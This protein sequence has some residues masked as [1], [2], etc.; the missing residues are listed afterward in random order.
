MKVAAKITT[1]PSRVRTLF[2]SAAL[3]V[4]VWLVF[5][6][7]LRHDF[8][9]FDDN[10]YV[11]GNSLTRSG[12]SWHG[13]ARAFVDTRT[14]NWHPVTLISHMLDCQLFDLK[15]GAHHF[16][17]V[18]LHSIAALLLF[19]FLRNATS[20][21]WSS[22]FIVALFAIHPLRVESVAWV[23][24]RKDV[25]SGVFFFLTLI[26]Y[27][28]Y[29]S[30]PSLHRYLTMSILFALG[31]MSKPMLVTT[32]VILL[33]LDYWPFRRFTD[34]KSFS[35]LAIEKI[36]LFGLSLVSSII[37]LSLQVHS[38]AL[39]GQLPFLWRLENALFSYITYIWQIF[40]PANLAVFYPHPDDRLQLWQ[41]LLGAA[42][43]VAVTWIA[44]ALRKNRPS[45]LVGWLWYLVMLLPVIGII[46]VGL[47]GHADRY[48][49]LPHV[50]LF[51][52]LTW[53]VV[54]LLS[55][56][57]HRKEILAAVGALVVVGLSFAAWKQT[58]Y[59]RNSETLWTHTLAVTKD[60]EVANTNLGMILADRGQF[61][62]ALSHLRSALGIRSGDRHHYYNLRRATILSDIGE[63]L[64]RKGELDDAISYFKQSLELKADYP[65]AR[66]NLG[67]TLFRKGDI[68]G[69][70]TEWNAVLSIQP[71][72]PETLT[73][74]AN[75]FV[76]KGRLRD[77]IAH[78]ERALQSE[79]ENARA[80]NNFAWILATA[81]DDSIRDGAKA[82][83]LAQRANRISGN[84]P[85]FIRTLAAAYAEAGQ[86]DAAIES[87][88]RA[89]EK[90]DAQA[91]P[92]LGSQIR[93][94]T[95]LYRQHRPLR[96]PSLQ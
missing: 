27:S 46:E 12:F 69:A 28:R 25:L 62:D 90:A 83:A 58:S 30:A 56:L 17:N 15:P 39:T 63:V 22:A 60:N 50:G 26:A 61:D 93:E 85:L 35:R 10:T 79:P 36:P 23:A 24:E 13:V 88:S 14:D 41:V 71:E 45:L 21:F 86:F 48:T 74:I 49:Y 80:L 7:T 77:A 96:D 52:A 44:F 67:A 32:P 55:S 65:F 8:V 87:A 51:V 54:D 64:F 4:V 3:V 9:N 1:T 84:D 66:Y 37:T 43:L 33:L 16:T 31:L 18:L 57:P 82:V 95:N 42:V 29:V 75:A 81:P 89:S 34:A 40:W 53:L 2:V 59:W 91:Q 78:Y 5:G 20:R 76:L 92:D 19:L 38:P 94:E 68:D 72:D 70:I 73:N 6:Q 11:Y 47:Q